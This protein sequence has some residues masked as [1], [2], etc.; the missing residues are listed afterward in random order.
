MAGN[1][2]GLTIKIGGDTTDLDKALKNVNTKAKSLSGEL[3]EVNRLLKFDPGNAD[4][5]A[6]KQQILAEAVTNT[7]EKLDTLKEAERQ[8][9]K[10]FERGEASVE[11]VRALHRE[12]VVTEQ[13]LG[14]YERAAKETAEAVERL[15]E[16]ADDAAK[17]IDDQADSAKDAAREN[18]DLDSSLDGLAKDF[19][20]VAAAATAV[21]AALVACVETS[22]DYRMEMG[23]LDTAFVT[24]GHSSQDALDTYTALV[25]VLGET[26]Q[27]VEASNHLAKM[28]ENTAELAQMTDAL[29]G[30]Y[31]TFGDSL[32][33]EGLAEA[34]NETAKVGKVTGPMAD[35]I[36]WA[37]ASTEDWND[38]L[39]DNEDALKAFNEGL[40]KGLTAEDAFNEAL[41]ATSDEQERQALIMDTLTELYGDAA[42]KY[43]KTNKEV[44]R[45]NE[46]NDK[47]NATLARIGETME[48]VVTD[49]KEFG[50]SLLEGV[51]E[52]LKNVAD[53]IRYKF[54][55]AVQSI[56]TWI[57]SNT[58]AI[59]AGFVGVTAALV[60]FRVATIAAEIAQKGLKGA[61]MKTT[62]AQKALQLAQAATP[63]G[64]VAVAIAG[65]TSALVAYN[66]KNELAKE[67]AGALTE[68]ERALMEQA[69][70]TAEELKEQRAAADEASGG[71]ASQMGYVRDLAT[72][73]QGLADASGRVQEKDQARVQFILGQLNEALGTEYSMVDGVI[74]QYDTLKSSIDSVIQSKTANALLEANNEAYVAAIQAEQELMAGMSIAYQDYITQL[75]ETQ[76]AQAEAAA[77]YDE[78]RAALDTGNQSIIH[79]AGLVYT[80]A[81]KNADKEA[82]LL[83]KKKA[84]YDE[85]AANYGENAEAIM[86][87][88]EAQTAALEGNYDRAIELLK[89]K[90]EAFGEYADNVD[91]E[92]ARALD[93]LLTEAVNAGIAAQRTRENFEN[94]VEGYTA[95]M[96]DEA[97]AG[98]EDALA[99]FANAKADAE[100]VGGDL[101]DGLA[102]GALR[103]RASIIAAASDLVR[104]FINK[105][106]Q[107]AQSHSPSRKMI[108]FGEDL[109]E[110]A[111]I[112]V[113]NSTKPLLKTAQKQVNALL[114]E[115][116]DLGDAVDSQIPQQLQAREAQRA[117][118]AAQTA[119]TSYSGTLGKILDAIERGQ[120][121]TID[122]DQLVGATA[123]R[124]DNK[125]GQRR[126]LA[127]RGA[128]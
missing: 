71:I 11:Q 55:P 94:G 53:F 35:A 108:A 10:Q 100:G 90:S 99:E 79:S 14:I 6:Q 39:G 126:A 1:L 51:E 87:F 31:A 4:L 67:S 24:S 96:V 73:L 58:P 40:E 120:V 113:E 85:A 86:N 64:L 123:D 122:G 26:D 16:N 29:T 57:A 27:A 114:D 69:A 37:N 52:P 15:G 119:A 20:I 44:I 12:I 43:K 3:S 93:A 54:L 83:E 36:N 66:V 47:W 13:K 5:L 103:K 107:E 22:R 60:A 74:Q 82:A 98:Y 32:P 56:G 92:T 30:V 68:A 61:I 48:P 19:G 121:L 23:K 110:G 78:Y 89:G 59:E 50:I 97:Q 112:G 49:V 127:A 101:G 7:R 76:T 38:A 17:E 115:Y 33:I 2:K 125:L 9:Q 118:A 46:A 77:A 95:A 88:E 63:W 45:A 72:E 116:S 41:A 104:S 81:Q 65:V 111:E 109:G 124:Y 106:R 18:E 70:E 105:A 128:V 8:V 42:K 62:V 34:A 102:G 91:A 80:D 25:G 117:T 84:A 21:A 28:T 75:A